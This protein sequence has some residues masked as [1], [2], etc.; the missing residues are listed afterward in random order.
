[1]NP[2]GPADRTLTAQESP[3]RVL[4]C[5]LLMMAALQVAVG[6]RVRLGE[7][8]VRPES[9]TN[10]AEALALLDGHWSLPQR[11]FDSAL[12]EGRVY[13]VNPPLFTFISYICAAAMRWQGEIV[14][15]LYRPWYV[16]LVALPLPIIGFAAFKSAT[17]SAARA[18]FMTFV[19]IAA[20][21]VLPCLE[22]ARGG[23]IS[24]INHLLSQTGLMLMIWASLSPRRIA[25]AAIGLVIAG[26]SRP[27][28][29]PLAIPLFAMAGWRNATDRGI[30]RRRVMVGIAV[31]A[32]VA[33]LMGVAWAKFGTPLGSGY[34]YVYEGRN[35]EMA[36]RGREGIFALSHAPRNAWYMNIAFPS[37]LL[38][39]HGLR[40]QPSSYGASI[41]L[42]MPILL[43][44]FIDVKKW[45]RDRCERIWMLSTFLVIVPLLL[46]HNTGYVQQGYFRYALDFLPVWL[47]VI[48]PRAWG[49]WR[50]AFTL[51]AAAW[52]CV[53][54]S[55]LP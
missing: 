38:D 10:L 22:N 12:F 47:I 41:W 51:G 9:N 33:T 52:S 46:Y 30:S 8:T 11:M 29:L 45:W 31:L 5:W 13:S 18:S 17:K 50:T 35:D 32:V 20:T 24:S 26:L 48:A 44:V 3:W 49:G 39:E 7:W 36:R 15:Q 40:P 42:T 27:T 55:L 34:R 6:H 4:G 37:W 1:M 2:D 53:Y 43:Y 19:W 23:G 16:M 54:F 28:T 25:G 21:P 14:T